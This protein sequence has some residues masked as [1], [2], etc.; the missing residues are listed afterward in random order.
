L[1]VF[2]FFFALFG[3]HRWLGEGVGLKLVRMWRRRREGD[4]G[5]EKG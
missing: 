5:V 1:Y 2:A 3:D 4:V